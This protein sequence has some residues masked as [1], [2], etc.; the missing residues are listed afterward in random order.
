VDAFDVRI[1]SM[2]RRESQRRPFEVRW[3]AAGRRRSRSFITRALADSYRAELRWRTRSRCGHVGCRV[4]IPGHGHR[5]RRGPQHRLAGFRAEL[6]AITCGRT[7]L[8]ACQ[9][10]GSAGLES[11]SP[12]STP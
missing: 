3:H 4:L 11:S 9:P 8:G 10:I 1:C 7:G 2:R 12:V 6:R 5:F